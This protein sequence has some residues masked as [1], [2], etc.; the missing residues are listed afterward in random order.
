MR[1]YMTRSVAS[2]SY[3]YDMNRKLLMRGSLLKAS[4]SLLADGEPCCGLG[5]AAEES[6][7]GF[8]PRLR[9]PEGA[10]TMLAACEYRMR[11][12]I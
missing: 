9:P 6:T 12:G 4:A 3:I 7:F 1:E 11:I 2:K 5:T 8:A 10:S